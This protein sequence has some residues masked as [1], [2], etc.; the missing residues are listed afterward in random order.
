MVF[1]KCFLVLVEKKT[2]KLQVIQFSGDVVHG[3]L[4]GLIGLLKVIGARVPESGNPAA[5]NRSSPRGIA[6]LL[7][8]YT[9][10]VYMITS[11]DVGNRQDLGRRVEVG[12]LR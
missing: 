4:V 3:R 7:I 11:P 5:G 10:L 12:S 6:S 2:E 8:D 9:R 1:E